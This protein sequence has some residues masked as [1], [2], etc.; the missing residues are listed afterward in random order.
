MEPAPSDDLA[1]RWPAVPSAQPGWQ[2][3]GVPWRPTNS[4]YIRQMWNGS[5]WVRVR[6][7]GSAWV[8]VRVLRWRP[9]A[10]AKWLIVTAVTWMVTILV[11]WAIVAGTNPDTGSSGA[12][13][14]TWTIAFAT[15]LGPALTPLMGIALSFDADPWFRMPAV[16]FGAGFV[17]TMVIYVWTNPTGPNSDPQGAPL[18]YAVIFLAAYI[19]FAVLLALGL[20]LGLFFKLIYRAIK[21]ARRKPPTAGLA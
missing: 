2:R 17:L 9:K 10:P 20:S 15:L 13:H 3:E 4:P 12:G 18:G 21:G 7:N 6:W 1:Q 16:A 11:P 5:A 8:P 14:I 19:G